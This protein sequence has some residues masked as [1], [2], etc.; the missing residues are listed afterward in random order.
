MFR[1]TAYE[2]LAAKGY[3]EGFI[4]YV[5]GKYSKEPLMKVKKRGTDGPE[6]M[7]V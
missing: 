5:S 3:H 7:L 2:L 4:P 6:E 1:R